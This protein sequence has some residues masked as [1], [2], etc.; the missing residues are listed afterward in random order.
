MAIPIVDDLAK[1]AGSL[2]GGTT[3]SSSKSSSGSKGKSATT[4][5]I[6]AGAQWFR[7]NT[8]LT[9]VKKSTLRK[10]K[11]KSRTKKRVLYVPT[12]R[13]KVRYM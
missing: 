10:L 8:R 13:R 4:A 11:A 6:K 5:R 2:V 1:A 12:M 7:K 3:T 9:V